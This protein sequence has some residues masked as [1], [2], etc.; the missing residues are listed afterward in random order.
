MRPET[1][2]WNGSADR[3]Q[4]LRVPLHWTVYLT[5]R[6]VPHPSRST[7]ENLSRGGFYCC[8]TDPLTP[9]DHIQCDIIVPTHASQNPDAVLVLRC[10]V[11]VLRVELMAQGY[12]LACRIDDF[13]VLQRTCDEEKLSSYAAETSHTQLNPV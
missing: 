13:S 7:T 12:G 3:R 10:Y 9:G 6:G 5:C 2:A 11:Q 8:V 4:S 1:Q